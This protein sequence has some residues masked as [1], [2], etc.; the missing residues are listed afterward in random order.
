M[1]NAAKHGGLVGNVRSSHRGRV[2]DASDE[3]EER[4]ALLDR[5]VRLGGCNTELAE[6]AY[7]LGFVGEPSRYSGRFAQRLIRQEAV[8]LL[9]D[10]ELLR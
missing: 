6:S 7:L 9:L 2:K 3:L 1:H 10:A 5:A 4:L 8:S